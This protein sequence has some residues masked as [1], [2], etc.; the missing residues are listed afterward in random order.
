MMLCVTGLLATYLL[1]SG[2]IGVRVYL[3]ERSDGSDRHESALVAMAAVA[4]WPLILWEE[5]A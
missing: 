1:F 2:Y 4:A 5:R 3:L